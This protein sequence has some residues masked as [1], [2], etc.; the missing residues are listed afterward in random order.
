MADSE[1]ETQYKQSF[2]RR[3]A[4]ARVALGWK[5]WQMAEA[6]GMPQD[7]YKQYEGRSLLPHHLIRRFCLIARVDMEWLMTGQGKMTLAPLPPVVP[8]IQPAPATKVR[9]TRRKVA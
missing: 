3:V 9:R 7:K 2:T 1:T 6:L 5:Q 8:D 4:E